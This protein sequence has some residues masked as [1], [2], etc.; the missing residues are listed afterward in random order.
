MTDKSVAALGG[1]EGRTNRDACPRCGAVDA[2]MSLLTSM[3][4][5]LACVRCRHRW[6]LVV[7]A[8]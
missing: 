2:V 8:E 1:P 3:H 4:K 5:Y 6:Q 7:D